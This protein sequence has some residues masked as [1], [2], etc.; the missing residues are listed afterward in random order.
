MNFVWICH[1]EE[2]A[3]L[4]R[5]SQETVRKHHPDATFTVYTDK[6]Y[7]LEGELVIDGYHAVPFMLMNLMCQ[8]HWLT[9]RG[10]THD[11]VVFLD[12]DAFLAKPIP[13]LSK[14]HD[15]AV[16]WRDNVGNVSKIMP[17]NYGVVIVQQTVQSI[18]GWSWMCNHITHQTPDNQKWYANQVA[19]REL[20][21]PINHEDTVTTRDHEY[22]DIRVRHFPCET[23][24]WTPEEG[25]PSLDGKIVV[26]CKGNRKDQLEH[27]YKEIMGA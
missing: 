7:E 10:A 16:T 24:N 27:Y 14:D 18:M 5:M 2:Y 13:L 6:V 19:L 22:F 12:V 4:C 26:H 3:R 8:T 20:C 1:G 17:Y 21:G 23:W 9:L 11:Q 15:V 25:L